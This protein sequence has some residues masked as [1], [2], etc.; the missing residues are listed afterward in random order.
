LATRKAK[1]FAWVAIAAL[2]LTTLSALLV[3]GR[4]GSG[5]TNPVGIDPTVIVTC[6]KSRGWNA[7]YSEPQPGT[8]EFTSETPLSVDDDERFR[9]D[10]K[11][12]VARNA[13]R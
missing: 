1:A 9:V 4:S 5:S 6:L 12:C 8:A 3:G 7:T 11:A 2:A 13:N 10:T